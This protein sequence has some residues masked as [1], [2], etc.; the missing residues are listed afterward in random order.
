MYFRYFVTITP[1]KRVLTFIW[2]NMNSFHPKIFCGTFGR[3]WP[4]G[5]G[6]DFWNC[7]CI[8]DISFLFSLEKGARLF[9]W[10][11]LNL[12]NLRP[13]KVCAK[14]GWNWPVVLEKILK[15]VNIFTLFHNHLLLE[16]GVTLSFQQ[17]WIP[18]TQG[19]FVPSL[20]PVGWVVLEKNH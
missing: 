20:V 18:V 15:F 4:S 7:Q 14:F 10:T 8:F 1:W 19:C 13:K 5:S 9:S 6:K 16:R 3:N 2:T 11:N 12:R 17:T